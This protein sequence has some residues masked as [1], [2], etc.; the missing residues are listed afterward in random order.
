MLQSSVSLIMVKI[1]YHTSSSIFLIIKGLFKI[2]HFHKKHSNISFKWYR[3]ALQNRTVPLALV[4]SF[5]FVLNL[6][7]RVD[8]PARQFCTKEER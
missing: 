3:K 2:Y 8:E 5:T 4:M 6:E 7:E 1:L